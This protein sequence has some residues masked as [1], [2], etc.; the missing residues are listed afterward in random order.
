MHSVKYR[1]PGEPVNPIILLNGDGQPNGVQARI[2]ING[3]GNSCCWRKMKKLYRKAVRYSVL[4]MP[5]TR[6]MERAMRDELLERKRQI[7]EA[8]YVG[9]TAYERN[10]E[11]LDRMCMYMQEEEV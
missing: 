4:T 6:P 10:Q 1:F 11:L 2:T 5:R 9:K 7:A 3:A 8:A